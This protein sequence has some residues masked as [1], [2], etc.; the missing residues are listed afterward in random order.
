[1]ALHFARIFAALYFALLFFAAQQEA[2][3]GLAH[4]SRKGAA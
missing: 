3:A 2:P 4:V 1:M